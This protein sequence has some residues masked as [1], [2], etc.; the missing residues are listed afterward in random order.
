M[1]IEEAKT[2]RAEIKYTIEYEKEDIDGKSSDDVMRMAE[3]ECVGGSGDHE[4]W[5]EGTNDDMSGWEGIE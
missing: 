2:I 4:Y 1:K 5:L 3:E